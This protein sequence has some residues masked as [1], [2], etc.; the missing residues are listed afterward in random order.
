MDG[1]I[2]VSPSTTKGKFIIRVIGNVTNKLTSFITSQLFTINFVGNLGPPSYSDEIT[3]AIQLDIGK[4]LTYNLP[5][6][7][8]P[9]KEDKVTVKATLG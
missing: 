1:K 6:I 8:D 5:S 3:K 4:S 2:V 9:D 7:T